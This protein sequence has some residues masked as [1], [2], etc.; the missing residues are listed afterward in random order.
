M[1]IIKSF[2]NGCGKCVAECHKNA[3]KK[4]GSNGYSIDPA[5]CNECA[6]I[7]DVEC[8]RVCGND[9]FNYDDGT[10]PV[11]DPTW[12]LRSEHG[13]RRIILRCHF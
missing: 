12:R 13:L 2:C 8:I 1:T 4:D 5:L 3:I 11:Y 6:D 9:A 7:F 10:L